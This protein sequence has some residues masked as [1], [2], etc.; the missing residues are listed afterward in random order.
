LVAQH[1]KPKSAKIL[2]LSGDGAQ[3]VQDPIMGAGVTSFPCDKLAQVLIN[4]G[5]RR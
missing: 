4:S 5:L 2:A 3:S 1:L